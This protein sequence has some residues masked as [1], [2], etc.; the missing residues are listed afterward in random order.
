MAKL[1]NQPRPIIDAVEM[2]VPTGNGLRRQIQDMPLCLMA[3]E[4]NFQGQFVLTE[5][6]FGLHSTLRR[7]I[8]VRQ[9]Q[10]VRI[11]VFKTR[12]QPIQAS[13][14]RGQSFAIEPAILKAAEFVESRGH[15]VGIE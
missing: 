2:D 10:I 6:P 8:H 4:V 5:R 15:V 11:T 3:A 14:C 1:L 12:R 9:R 13:R 7:W